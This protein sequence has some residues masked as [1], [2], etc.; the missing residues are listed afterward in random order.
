MGERL[1]T[2]YDRPGQLGYSARDRK[3]LDDDQYVHNMSFP[4]GQFAAPI[5]EAT[6]R[7][8]PQSH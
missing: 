6:D 5:L 8:D 4:G 7:T 2:Y 3:I 1:D